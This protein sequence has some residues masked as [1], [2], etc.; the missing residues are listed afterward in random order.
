MGSEAIFK[1]HLAH[2]MK[3][4]FSAAVNSLSANT[5]SSASFIDGLNSQVNVAE[6]K[7]CVSSKLKQLIFSLVDFK[8]SIIMDGLACI[9]EA[10]S[11]TFLQME[12]FC[13]Q[14]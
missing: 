8:I 10:I 13:M 11:S 3:K 4:V 5:P 12:Q 14:S 7:E 1:D 2:C 9:I 6:K